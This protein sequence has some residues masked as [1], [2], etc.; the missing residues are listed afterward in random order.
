MTWVQDGGGNRA[1]SN[2]NANIKFLPTLYLGTTHTA[3]TLST[4]GG[5]RDTEIFY[6]EDS[7]HIN[8]IARNFN[9]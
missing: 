3:P 1:L 2:A 8:E 9:N 7:T 5:K 6:C 4:T